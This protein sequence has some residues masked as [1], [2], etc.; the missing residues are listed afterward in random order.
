MY[1]YYSGI[2]W[3]IDVVL[4]FSTIFFA[5]VILLYSVLK[6]H[7]EKKHQSRLLNIKKHVYTLLVS[8]DTENT[9][10]LKFPPLTTHDFL[11]IVINR[12]RDMTFFNEAEQKTLKER[13]STPKNI[14]KIEKTA[15]RSW[16]KWRRIEA[17]LCLGYIGNPSALAILEKSLQSR[18]ADVAYFSIVALSQIKTSQ[19]ATILLRF[20]RKD[21]VNRQGIISVL[22]SFP[23]EIVSV[24]IPILDDK[25]PYVRIAII[26]LI[27]K[28]KTEDCGEKIEKIALEDKS[29]EVRAAACT[30]LGSFGNEQYTKT[31][32]TSLNDTFWLVKTEAA[33][34]LSK[35]LGGRCIPIIIKLAKDSSWS[36]IESIKEMMARHIQASLPYIE[37]FLR[38]DDPVTSRASVEALGSSGYTINILKDV[39][40]GKGDI[41]KRADLILT[42]IVKTNFHFVLE[43]ALKNLDIDS[44]DRILTIIGAVNKSVSDKLS[45]QITEGLDA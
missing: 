43:S 14:T 24:A 28:F 18:N 10:R 42:G 1:N 23:K 19:S 16:Y 45:K 2:I 26:G 11:D 12:S 41:K 36:V 44:R 25:D 37:K 15:K 21:A 27:G 40:H 3:K 20:L 33:K 8:G 29:G 39:L 31:L 4:L 6:E 32:T 30:C 5:G 35:I 22:E 9:A 7:S 38:E 34:A 17:L 13:F